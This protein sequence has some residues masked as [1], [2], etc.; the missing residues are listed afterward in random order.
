ML[1]APW[2]LQNAEDG[3]ES[4]H[5]VVLEGECDRLGAAGGAQI[6]EDVADVE[7]D[8]QAADHLGTRLALE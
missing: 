8:G 2:G 4:A 6:G 7:P 5:Q 3:R 1:L